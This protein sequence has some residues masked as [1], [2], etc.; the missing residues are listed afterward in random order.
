MIKSTYGTGCFVLANTGDKAAVSSNRLL[1][2][3]GYRL[4]GKTTYALEGSIFMAGA[5]VQWLR[6]GL[7]LVTHASDT[8]ALAEAPIRTVR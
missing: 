1:T 8:Q 6:D 7:Q 4:D 3:I 2:T 5:I